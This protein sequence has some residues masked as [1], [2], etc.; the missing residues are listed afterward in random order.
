MNLTIIGSGYVGLTTG[1]CFAEMGHHVICVDN[2]E[3][4]IRTL[5][6]GAI[7]IYEPKLEDLVK[8]NV[9][10][11]RLEFS[12]SIADSIAE[13]EVIFIAVPTPPN[14]DGSVDL[15]YIE[16]VAREIAQVLKP[17]MGYKVI[18]DKSTVPVKTGEKVTETIKRYAGPDVQFDIVSNPEFLREGCAVDDLLQPD[19]I[20]IGANSE[21]AMTVIKR[22]YQPIHAP[23][24]ETDVSSAELIKHA[25]NSF[26]ALKISYINAVA[27]VCEKTGADVKLVAEGIG[28]DKRISRHF[29]N[30]GLGY[31]GSCFPKDVKAFINISRTLGTPFTLLEEVERIND[32]QH[33]HFLDQIRERLWVLKDKKIAVWGLAFKQNTDDIRESVAIRLC[34]KLR[35]EGAAVTATDPKAMNT[36]RPILEPLGVTLVED[37][38]ECARDAEVLIIATEWSEYAN[39]DLQQLAGVMRNRIIFDGRNI[40]SPANIRAVGFEYHSVGRPSIGNA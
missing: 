37:M 15:T 10:V 5:Q 8:K 27:K 38:Y 6:S 26:L 39:A 36:A 23:I 13:S 35:R 14:T 11:G 16:K 18:V 22:V 3:E 9:A 25:A 7:P 28:M 2:N 33:V 17:E 29:L 32:T 1:T 34:Q 20:V 21:R 24:L 12:P 30:A 40:L 4:K 19:R 31:G